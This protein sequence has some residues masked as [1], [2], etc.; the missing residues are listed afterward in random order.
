M[1]LEHVITSCLQ[2]LQRSMNLDLDLFAESKD[3]TD[4]AVARVAV[5][6]L[7]SQPVDH[8]DRAGKKRHQGS[9]LTS[10][11]SN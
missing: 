7:M 5:E 3:A 11:F 8:D 10:A 2:V 1:Q 9:R 6:S 4:A